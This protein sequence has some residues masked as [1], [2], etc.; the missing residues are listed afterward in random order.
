[1]AESL[2]VELR[3]NLGKR[4]SRR[5]RR[6]GQV[7]AVLYGH[8]GEVF[9]L[10]VPH[11]QVASMLR[12][13]SRLVELRGAVQE[14]AFVNEMQWDVYGTDVVHL[15]FIRVAEGEKVELRV[16]IEL[17]G[18][19]PGV[20][21][22]GALDLVMHEL[23]IECPVGVIPEKLIVS[24]KEL[25]I[26][27]TITAG[28]VTLPEGASLI[29]DADA[30]VVTCHKLTEEGEEGVSVGEGAEPEVIGRKAGE[31]AADEE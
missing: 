2:T 25:H 1:M 8:G 13:G 16:K 11:E 5:I 18:E 4:H 26:E 31:E 12:H 6:E 19:A 10:T 22:G 28:Q 3:P 23:E 14:T 30:V 17:K 15:D 7:P 24:V 29:T 20:K 21:E 27:Q 9:S